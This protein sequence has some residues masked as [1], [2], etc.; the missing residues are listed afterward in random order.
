MGTILPMCFSATASFAGSAVLAMLGGATLL[1][2]RRKREIPLALI[3]L[4]FAVQ[5]FFEGWVWVNMPLEGAEFFWAYGFLFFAF[6]FWPFYFPLAGVFLEEKGWRRGFQLFLWGIGTMTALYLG[7]YLF[8][9]PLEVSVVNQCLRYYVEMPFIKLGD[10]IYLAAVALPGLFSSHKA[11]RIFGIALALSFALSQWLY[12]QTFP[13]VWCFF[14]AILSLILLTHFR[15][16]L[17]KKRV[18]KS[19]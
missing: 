15:P 3:P 13:S 17:F 16:N 4:F 12:A 6:I 7:L 9:K 18:K 5:Q 1:Q 2:V 14:S 19:S 8:T 11:V 10:F